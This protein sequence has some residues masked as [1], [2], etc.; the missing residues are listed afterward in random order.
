MKYVESQR[1]IGLEDETGTPESLK[2]STC[3]ETSKT[4]DGALA[5]AFKFL[6]KR[7]NGV[8]LGTL[9]NGSSGFAE[10]KRNVIGIS[11]SVLSERL[12]ELQAAGLIARSVDPGP[13]V[14]VS[15]ELIDTRHARPQHV[16]QRELPARYPRLKT[17]TNV[18]KR[19]NMTDRLI[20]LR[21]SVEHLRA[22][23]DGVEVLV[24]ET[25]AYPAEWTI[26]DTMSHIGSG[27]V[28]L[29]R[30]FEDAVAGQVADTGF[31]QSVWDEWN[32]KAPADQ[33]KDALVADEAL[34]VAL[35]NLPDDARETFHF[36]MGP[37]NL[38][39][40][41]FV[42]IRLSEQALHT[43]DVEVAIDPTATLSSDV[44]SAILDALGRIVGF[45]GKANGE[46]KE[47]RVRTTDPS[48]DF[49]LVFSGES[50]SLLEA[51][52]AGDVDVELP[53]EAFVRLVYGR[54]DAENSPVDVSEPPL[55][56]LTKAFPGF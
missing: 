4:C 35:E 33:V 20:V 26:A 39:F 8:L 45:A 17:H 24:P 56:S 30:R 41:G 51:S 34:L 14:S 40:D 13:P 23:I 46:T 3:D 50:V 49:T 21:S 11:D 36:V 55:D 37:F 12:S 32:A 43:W 54:L 9:T 18:E 15:Y 47:V 28:I 19:D 44:A 2:P 7:W 53:A 29:K 10:L 42:G 6:G 22:V 1:S 27:A 52:H 16:G 25:S 5:Q 31:N 48:R 38:D